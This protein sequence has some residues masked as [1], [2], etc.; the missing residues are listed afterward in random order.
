MARRHHRSE[1][2]IFFIFMV[3]VGVVF[4]CGLVLGAGDQAHGQ[5]RSGDLKDLLYRIINFS[6]LVIILF[7]ALKKV[8]IKHFF[9]SRGE[10]IK[11]KLEELNKNKEEAERKYRELEKRLQEFDTHKKNVLEQF[12]AEGLTEKERIVAEARTKVNQ[13]IEEAEAAIGQEMQ[14]ARERLKSDVTALTTRRAEEII[15]REIT[16]KDQNNLVNDFIERVG[17]GH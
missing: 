4:F 11:K 1:R 16:E 8:G 15:L 17:K 9:A 2:T 5:D 10:E 3:L 14:A 7:V 13:I 12:R 6:L